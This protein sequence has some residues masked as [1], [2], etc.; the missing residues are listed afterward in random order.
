MAMNMAMVMARRTVPKQR[1][2]SGAVMRR[3]VR[4][5]KLRWKAVVSLGLLGL[6]L[7]WLI[8]SSGIGNAFAAVDPARALVFQPWS[9]RA[10]ATLASQRFAVSDV[11]AAAAIQRLSAR[12][13]RRDATEYFA[14][15]SLA[16]VSDTLGQNKVSKA[17]FNYVSK[18]TR[19]DLLANL[20]FIED[21]VRREDV[22]GALGYFDQALKTTNEAAEILFPILVRAFDDPE[23][24][25][26][27]V[28]VLAKKPAWADSFLNEAIE[29]GQQSESI[30]RAALI[31]HKRKAD[32]SP[33]LR[34]HAL[35][36]LT[37]LGAYTEAYALYS[38]FAPEALSKKPLVIDGGFNLNRGEYPFGWTLEAEDRFGAERVVRKGRAGDN[39]LSV[40]A[41]PSAQ[42]V[43]ARQLLLLPTGRYRLTYDV[44]LTD[45]ESGSDV[46]WRITCAT[47]RG[48]RLATV[49]VTSAQSANRSGSFSVPPGCLAQWLELAVSVPDSTQDLAVVI[50]NLTVKAD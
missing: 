26:P 44:V 46:N 18:L 48:T 3:L 29:K 30:Y 33:N 8:V 23:L 17:Q 1:T 40:F 13:L 5:V 39:G 6:G 28:D 49:P 32:L 24:F 15:R 31:L 10:N 20:W 41:S 34:N 43:P 36:R 9:S 4:I 47:A 12:A 22:K 7:A 16:A 42:G 21:A 50:D 37:A 14:M 38:G 2:E 19:R 27:L 45:E 25:G 35:Y 11:K